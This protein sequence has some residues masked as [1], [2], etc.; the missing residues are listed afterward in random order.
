MG[1]C[2]GHDV[3]PCLVEFAVDR[4]R[5]SVDGSVADDDITIVVDADEVAHGHQLEVVAERVDPE[6]VGELGVANSDV[7][8]H[9]L[10]E[11]EATHGAQPTGEALLAALT[12]GFHVLDLRS[13]LLLDCGQCFLDGVGHV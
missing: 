8:C 10:C 13:S 4:K 5:R 2:G 1:V 7:A 3:G 12:L 11:M 6:A 9:T